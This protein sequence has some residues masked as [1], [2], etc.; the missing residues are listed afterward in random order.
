MASRLNRC[1]SFQVSPP[2]F[3]CPPHRLQSGGRAGAQKDQGRDSKSS[4]PRRG[5]TPPAAAAPP[6]KAAAGGRGETV[7]GRAGA[8]RIGA[9][10]AT[11]PTKVSS[12]LS[13]NSAKKQSRSKPAGPRL[14]LHDGAVQVERRRRRPVR[15]HRRP[16]PG[17]PDPPQPPGR[18]RQE[19]LARGRGVGRLNSPWRG[20][21]EESSPQAQV[22]WAGTAGTPGRK[23]GGPPPYPPWRGPH[24]E[25]SPGHRGEDNTVPSWSHGRGLGRR[26]GAGSGTWSLNGMDG[27]GGGT[28]TVR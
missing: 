26:A 22:R 16:A 27:G 11:T 2:S 14:L 17:Q 9:R 13:P 7:V 18:A 12:S 28:L 10:S 1:C 24:G 25:S 20:S 5:A 15:R 4:P 23:K 21:H 19:H 6:R 8:G 3:G